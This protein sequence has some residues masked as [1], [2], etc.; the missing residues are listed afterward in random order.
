M[1]SKRPHL[2]QPLTALMSKKVKF[3]WKVVKQKSLD[4]IKQIVACDTLLIYPEFNTH[5]D[6][7]TDAS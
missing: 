2:L 6:I 1:W 5:L 4:E 7:H 3:K